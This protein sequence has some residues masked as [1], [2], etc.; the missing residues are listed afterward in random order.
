MRMIENRD[1]K[2]R[3]DSRAAIH[4]ELALRRAVPQC[5]RV[6]VC[7]TETRKSSAAGLPEQLKNDRDGE[8]LRIA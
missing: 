1:G 6:R 8:F 7:G 4:C 2:Y 5:G 3:I